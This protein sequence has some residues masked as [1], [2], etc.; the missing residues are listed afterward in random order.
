MR[1]KSFV[2]QFL[3]QELGYPSTS[4]CTG[5]STSYMVFSTPLVY[6][7]QSTKKESEIPEQF[8]DDLYYATGVMLSGDLFSHADVA[9]YVRIHLGSDMANIEEMMKRF[10]AAGLN[11]HMKHKLG[12]APGLAERLVTKLRNLVT[13]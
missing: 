6:S 3:E 9:A 8:A 12:I 10:K 11:Y 2:R 13:T 1:K 5:P 4:I 7:E